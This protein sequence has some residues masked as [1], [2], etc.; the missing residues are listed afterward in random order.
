[1]LPYVVLRYII[2]YNYNLL[3]A[4]RTE[5]SFKAFGLLSYLGVVQGCVDA[6]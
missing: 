3:F 6:D 2:L 4:L 1:M 5:W